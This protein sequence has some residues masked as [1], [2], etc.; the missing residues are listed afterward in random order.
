MEKMRHCV[1]NEVAIRAEIVDGTPDTELE[2]F[3]TGTVARA[4]LSKGD[5]CHS[6]QLAFFLA[7]WWWTSEKEAIWVQTREG[8]VDYVGVNGVHR[9][10]DL[11]MRCRSIPKVWLNRCQELCPQ[12]L[13]A[14][15]TA[16]VAGDPPMGRVVGLQS[17]HQKLGGEEFK[18]VLNRQLSALLMEMGD[19]RGGVTTGDETKGATLDLL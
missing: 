17:L 16:M 8:V 14:A 1:R 7:Y 18:M 13:F 2:V 12:R 5:P 19:G 3:E 10:F 6:R 11:S 15:A 9:L 4:E